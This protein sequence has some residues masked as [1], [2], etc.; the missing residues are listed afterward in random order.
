MMK[1]KNSKSMTALPED[2]QLFS[3]ILFLTIG[4]KFPKYKVG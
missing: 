1:M 4:I 2:Y 3:V